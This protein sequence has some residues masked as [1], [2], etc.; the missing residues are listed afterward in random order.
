L[1]DLDDPWEK[2]RMKRRGR[3]NPYVKP[4][5]VKRRRG[6]EKKA[7]K[8]MVEVVKKMPLKNK[9]PVAASPQSIPLIFK[10]AIV[11]GQIPLTPSKSANAASSAVVRPVLTKSAQ[12]KNSSTAQNQT[13]NTGPNADDNWT[14][15]IFR[16]EYMKKGPGTASAKQRPV[17]I[18]SLGYNKFL[19][20][21]SGKKMEKAAKKA[22]EIMK[23]YFSLPV[24]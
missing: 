14:P 9:K 8:K 23:K 11:Y 21:K 6:E 2:R 15:L 22:V 10:P 7:K 16:P 13:A 18:F 20:T 4:K 24:F 1:D 17:N 19:G 3:Y 12:V 5:M